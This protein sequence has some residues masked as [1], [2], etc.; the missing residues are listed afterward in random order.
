[1]R[2]SEQ[3][4]IL[5]LVSTL[6][7]ANDAMKQLFLKK[8]YPAVNQ[9]LS[10]SQ[11][12]AVQI[13]AYIEQ[14][15][16]EETKTVPLLEE[17]CNLLYQISAQ[18][19]DNTDRESVYSKRL[20]KHL[21]Q[22]ENSVRA[23][24][25]P[26]KLEVVFFPYKASM[27]D[28]LE[29]VWIAAKN[30]PQCDVY[31]VPIPY[32]NKLS[33]GSFG[34]MHYEGDR[35]PGY[36]PVVDWRTYNIEERRPDAIF[37]H[38]PYDSA[39]FVTSVH[40]DYYN[41]RLKS[42]TDL[43]VYIPYFVAADDVS[44]P[45][46]VCAGTL[47]ADKVLIQSEKIRDIYIKAFH[48]FER[49]NRCIGRFGKAKDK[50]IAAGSPKFDKVL[51]AKP[52][53]FT[54]SD[55]WRRL[56]TR[57]DGTQKKI[58]LYN[59]TIGAILTGNE[60][61]LRK[62]N[63]V[64]EAFKNRDDMVLWWRPHPL[65]QET[66]RT[67]R[68]QLLQEYE[69]I[70][71]SY[72]SN[73]TGIYDDTPDLH[74][75]ICFASCY[76][77]DWS[78]LVPMFGMT[79]K[80]VVI[81][82]ITKTEDRMPLR[83]ADFAV[84]SEGAMWGFELSV[85][86]L[87]QLNPANNIAC[88]AAKSGCMPCAGGKKALYGRRYMGIRCIGDE[89]ICFPVLLDNIFI[90]NRKSGETAFVPLDREYLLSQ[91]YGG[92]A[93]RHII[94]HHGKVY[95]FG[96]YAKA[97]VVFDVASRNVRYDTAL[98]EQAGLLIDGEQTENRPVYMS[99]CSGNG[100]I[101]LL[102][103]NSEHLIRYTLPTREIAFIASNPVLSQCTHAD[104]DGQYFWLLAETN[105]KLIKWDSSSNRVTEYAVPSN[106]SIHAVKASVFSGMSDC[107]EY[108][109]LFPS[110]GN[111]M[112]KFDKKTALFS[113]CKEMAVPNDEKNQIFKYY[114]PKNAGDKIYAFAHHNDSMYELDKLSGKIS[115]HRFSF[116]ENSKKQYFT[117]YLD[118]VLDEEN[119]SSSMFVINEQIIDHI[120]CF[121]S[122]MIASE[123][124]ARNEKQSEHYL[125]LTAN[126][127]GT[128]GKFIYEYVRGELL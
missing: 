70:V 48:D 50:F 101:I 54:V 111:A 14:L 76:Y 16:G 20:R 42:F 92:F 102:F 73:K 69:R 45:F 98:F 84:D 4:Q 11:Q 117:D 31:V 43:L 115:Q 47:Y 33:D 91:E 34:Q 67:M 128:S 94:E 59:T 2:K 29:S 38:N 12:F 9:L 37:T 68:P 71:S 88:Y 97:V 13:G 28:S 123:Q 40:P 77:G 78:S 25:R 126:P 57:P 108:L 83:F 86:G 6:N 90:Y 10:D 53:D 46:C 120:A 95:C 27:W 66:Y 87:F 51:N 103:R 24:L 61:Y 113:G 75:A 116:D 64:V 55:E 44:E 56:I 118:L 85:D 60:Q 127:D 30:D 18:I 106:V 99:E 58:V 26:D 107:G 52:E 82:D 96:I 21:I 3:K 105:D 122:L 81:Q 19:H 41:E 74:K 112:L 65:N 125:K 80:P 17:Y 35:Y 8:D 109:L 23:E 32:Y 62:L 1:M 110:Y 93:F 22:I 119:A 49:S 124:S 121:L 100:E 89:V 15:A 7:E 104:F 36:V 63:H 5:E 39:N 114:K 72:K 79:G